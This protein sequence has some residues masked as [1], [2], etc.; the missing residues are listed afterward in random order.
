MTML[1]TPVD[2][3]TTTDFNKIKKFFDER[4]VELSRWTTKV[5]LTE[6]A[7]QEEV[8]SAYDHELKPYMQR[9]GFQSCDVINVY[10][11]LPNKE[12]IRNKFISEHTHSEDEVRF[13]VEGQGKFWFHLPNDEVFCLICTEGDFLSVPAGVKHWFDLAPYYHVKAI[14]VFTNKDGWVAHYTQSKI[15][16][17]YNATIF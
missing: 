16:E 14:R 10:P 7:S 12:E 4:G 17:K 11:S 5:K 6:T 3:K 2:G 13:F 9:K 8:L 1:F 15:D